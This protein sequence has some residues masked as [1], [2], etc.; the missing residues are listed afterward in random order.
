MK[1]RICEKNF[2]REDLYEGIFDDKIDLICKNCLVKEDVPIIKKPLLEETR[3]LSVK[4]RVERIST[5]QEKIKKEQTITL[6]N[7]SK[8]KFPPKKEETPDLVENYYWLIQNSRRR[9]KMT[10]TQLAEKLTIPLNVLISLE[11]G[12]IPKNFY[13]YIDK[14]EGFFKI[15]LWK[16]NAREKYFPVD[17][18]EIQKEVIEEVEEKISPKAEKS[19]FKRFFYK[20]VDRPKKKDKEKSGEN[21][22]EGFMEV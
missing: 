17:K 11:K 3:N 7:L 19:L 13:E 22:K 18:E 15:K 20:M 21:L 8:L 1:C 6:A 4:E 9:M 5:K 16:N 10:Q 14:L 12:Q 2:D